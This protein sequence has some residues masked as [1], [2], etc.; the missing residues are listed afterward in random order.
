MCTLPFITVVDFFRRGVLSANVVYALVFSAVER[1][2]VGKGVPGALYLQLCVEIIAYE[3][4][5]WY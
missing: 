5:A 3:G 2:G 4:R 1:G